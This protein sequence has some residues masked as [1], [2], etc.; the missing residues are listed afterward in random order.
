MLTA[1]FLLGFMGSLHCIGMCGP[2]ALMAC[3]HEGDRNLSAGLYYNIGRIITYSLLGG[4]FGVVGTFLFVSQSQKWMAIALGSFM[5]LSFFLGRDIDT[6]LGKISFLRR[7]YK[8]VQELIS[9]YFQKTKKTSPFIIGTLN[10]LLP[11]GLVYL[12]LAGAI[13]SSHWTDSMLF[14]LVFG[15]GT[16]P[17]MLG[18]MSGY[19]LL[20]V[21]MRANV[22]M[23]LPIVSFVFGCFLIYRGIYVEMPMELDFWEAMKNPV[24]RH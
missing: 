11:C 10:G 17:A 22:K 15:V 18:L 5:I 14:M 7:Y 9:F 8:K 19:S 21:K 3:S 6:Q 2:L 24:L 23:M 16:L 1:A 12:A 13:S 20:T 4:L